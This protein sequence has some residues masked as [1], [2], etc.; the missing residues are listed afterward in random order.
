MAPHFILHPLACMGRANGMS[1][2]ST[3]ESRP[4]P[5]LDDLAGLGQHTLK[6]RWPRVPIPHRP[7]ESAGNIRITPEREKLRQRV[8]PALRLERRRRA[9]DMKVQVRPGGIDARSSETRDRLARANRVSSLDAK[10][11]ALQML[12]K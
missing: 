5:E 3:S 2:G 12:V 6:D 9:A 11:A 8:R 1:S 4:L 10:A 7:F